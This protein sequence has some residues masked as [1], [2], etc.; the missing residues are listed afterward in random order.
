MHNSQGVL[1]LSATDLVG[2][3]EC[4]HLTQL[5]RLAALG[6][7]KRPKRDDPA[8]DLLSQL[9]EEH[10]REHLN[11]YRTLG[12]KIAVI[13]QR[14]M[15]PQEMKR[16]EGDTL[17]AMRDGADV[18]YQGTFFDG[19]WTGRADYLIKIAEPSGLGD[20]SYEVVD[21]KL[22]R[23]AKTRALLQVAIYSEQLARLQGRLPTS[24]RLILGDDSEHVFRVHDFVSYARV[25]LDRLEAVLAA[26]PLPSYPDKVHHC[27]VCRWSD[28][29]DLKRRDDD[30]LS[31]VAGIRRDQIRRLAAAAI[32]TTTALAASTG[33]V[34]GIGQS[35][36]DRIR[37]QSELQ[38]EAAR[39]GERSY[40]LIQEQAPGLGLGALPEPS[41]GDLFFDM[42]GDPYVADGGLEYLFG[43]VGV[44][45]GS[46]GY[47]S[48]WAHDSRE[49]KIAF[50]GFVDFVMDRWQ[51]D[52]NLHVYH[53]ASYETEALKRLMGRHGSREHEIDRMLRGGL[54]VDLYQV[55]RQ[56]VRISEEAYS[57]KNVERFYRPERTE[58]VLDAGSSIV[59]YERWRREGDKK[60]LIEIEQY[61]RAD[62][63][64][65]SQLRD[66]LEERRAEAIGY[67]LDLLRPV[68][69]D[70][71]PAPELA[72]AEVAVHSLTEA[73]LAGVAD[74]RMARNDEQQARWLL[75]QSLSWHRREAKADWWAYFQRLA[76]T[77]DELIEDTEAI[78]GIE[79][80]GE[81]AQLKQSVVRRYRFD[82]SQEYKIAVGDTPEDPL[83]QER[84]GGVVALDPFAGTIDLKR[85][86]R[87]LWPHPASLIP[88]RPFF[89]TEQ[90][91]AVQRLA[92]R[93]IES[94]FGAPG[95][96]AASDL[97]LRSTPRIAGRPLG[98]AVVDLSEDPGPAA[99]V[100]VM[101]LENTC[102]P[103]Q[104]PPGTGKT[105]TGARMVLD[106]IAA[107]R[108][109]G[110]TATSH[111]VIGNL[112]LAIIDASGKEGRGV[113]V[114]QKCDEHEFCGH[115]D[116]EPTTDNGKVFAALVSS[117]VDVVGGTAWLWS[118]PEM[119]HSIDTLFVDEAGQMSLANVLAVASAA[120]TVVLLG[121]PRQ[122]SQ[123]S[124]GSH[125]PGSDLSALDHVLGGAATIAPEQGV[126]LGTTWRMHRDVCGFVSAASYEGRLHPDES[127]NGQWVHAPGPLTGTGI[128]YLPATH[129]GN[130][131]SS[132][133][134]AEIVVRLFN[135]L[136]HGEWRDREGTVRPMRLKD[137]LVV[138]PFN[139]QVQL[140]QAMLPPESRVGTVDKFQGQEAPVVI[141][142][143][144]TSSPDDLPRGME[145]LY[146]LNRLNVAVSR[147]QSLAAVIC[148]PNLLRVRARTPEQL[149]LASAMCLLVETSERFEG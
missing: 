10:E 96:E 94:G 35:A 97:L 131:T 89:T 75:A 46:T 61:N 79:F 139:A 99:R 105:Y 82:P 53:Y 28:V 41:A 34:E 43:L 126:F 116:V 68:R 56:G 13:E 59:E 50:E 113:R 54:F 121:D 24:M 39:T 23:H 90:R 143:L 31:L 37:I 93:V 21:A 55:V 103:I 2:H 19:R 86:V 138:A 140:L 117:S 12:L 114:M 3:L 134:E 42:E 18:I 71:E 6:E 22:A 14:E 115:P 40:A 85:G 142:T 49:E 141:Y 87:R 74:D 64:S 137:I 72:A 110:V 127:C 136:L 36:L 91:Q 92:E 32:H 67:G 25:A 129:W 101:R 29:C 70:P 76:M 63:E 83:S 17:Q 144:A 132:E 81:V 147:A 109:V 112:L 95:I 118:R 1:V 48:W 106:L 57:L 107:G 133:E 88:A 33:P 120:R 108:K 122:V 149:R 148:S 123:P 11:R 125:P 60:V 9:G 119:A 102:L 52:L 16:A 84:A 26:S 51:Q 128:R 47:R 104:G 73:V 69:R 30:H 77:D 78:G 27:A 8:L 135:D 62:C 5:E 44:H 98:A 45:E 146:S 65:T 124:N 58:S 7:L 111:K 66:W 4:E 100:V 80:V 145:F 20:H 130:R 38:V 15:T